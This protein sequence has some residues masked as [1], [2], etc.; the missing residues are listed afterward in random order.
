MFVSLWEKQ[1]LL[2]P[3]PPCPRGSLALGAD[4]GLQCGP[5]HPH[6]MD[7][8]L[9][10]L[11]TTKLLRPQFA[12]EPPGGEQPPLPKDE[13][14]PNSSLAK[15]D[16]SSGYNMV[17]PGHHG[18]RIHVTLRNAISDTFR[19]PSKHRRTLLGFLSP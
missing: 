15:H 4:P 5:S 11:D 13:I 18:D 8:V 7:R 19:G 16:D 9:L 1:R 17:V 2:C 6:P 12:Q 14:Q 10:P 3:A